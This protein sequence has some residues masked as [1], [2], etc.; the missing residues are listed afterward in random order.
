MALLP[1][2]AASLLLATS[3][4]TPPSQDPTVLPDVEVQAAARADMARRFVSRIAAP[5]RNRGLARWTSVC[6]IVVNLEPVRAREIATRIAEVA[7]ELGIEVGDP[8]C[9]GNL[10]VVFTEDAGAVTR[11]MTAAHPDVYRASVG[12]LS[13]GQDA[14]QDFLNTDRPVRWWVVSLPV[15]PPHG[16]PGGADAW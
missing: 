7:D 16:R 13:R 4:Q 11:A 12:P 8:G 6:P 10:V 9:R 15:D 14:F 1:T 3:P 5:S 2:L